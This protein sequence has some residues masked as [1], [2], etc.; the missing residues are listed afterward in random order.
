MILHN[1]NKILAVIS[2]KGGV[3][4]TTLVA[5]LGG[6]LAAYAK[7]LLVDA[8]PQPSLSSYYPIT[9]QAR[10]G[11]VE[12]LHYPEKINECISK[13]PFCDLIYSNDHEYALQNWLIALADG[14]FL[15]KRAL[16][17]LKES[18]DYII[19]DTQ[20]AK[21][22]LQDSAIICAHILLSPILP[23]SSAIKEFSRGTLAA[24]KRLQML[25]DNHA[26]IPKLNTL[27]YRT[28]H[29]KNAQ[30]Y[31][32]LFSQQKSKQSAY[33]I[34][35]T[36]IPEA[37]IFKEASASKLP[38]GHFINAS[39][40]YQLKAKKSVDAIK[41]LLTELGLLNSTRINNVS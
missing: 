21:G 16:S 27:I 4:K 26:S 37:V 6:Y 7:V 1:K 5:N 38:I 33:L 18:Y 10:G 13:T 24:L 8:D 12:V 40:A 29:T 34:L 41:G 19:I 39:K 11:L 36:T 28:N 32:H 2:T 15:L 20:G 22:A 17:F 25:S 30:A 23:E 31:A 14:P 9:Y 35:K 3:G